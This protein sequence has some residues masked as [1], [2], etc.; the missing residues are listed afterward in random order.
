MADP[1]YRLFHRLHHTV[2]RISVQAGP[3][4]YEVCLINM[5]DKNSSLTLHYN[6]NQQSN[7]PNAEYTHDSEDSDDTQS[8][9]DITWSPGD[10]VCPT[11][12]QF[13]SCCETK[14]NEWE[15]ATSIDLGQYDTLSR[16]A[17]AF[18][19]LLKDVPPFFHRPPEHV[20]LTGRPK[21]FLILRSS[22]LIQTTGDSNC[23]QTQ[24]PIDYL[25]CI[26]SPKPVTYRTNT[27]TQ[28]HTTVSISGNVLRSGYF[29]SI[30]LAWSYIISC[31]WVEILQQAGEESQILH[32]GDTQIEDSFWDIVTQGCWVAHVKKQKGIFYS[33]WMLRREGATEK[34]YAHRTDYLHLVSANGSLKG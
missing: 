33:P 18:L 21:A 28:L 31:Y 7:V 4:L 20:N 6:H 11:T 27:E 13:N 1:I 16:Y 29:T 32:N 26:G 9:D 17:R 25:Q 14:L 30:A 22:L 34:R 15:K 3:R 10:G 24:K 23:N 5:E 8:D 19:D 12:A 2:F